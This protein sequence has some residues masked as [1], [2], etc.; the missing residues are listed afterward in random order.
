M[1]PARPAPIDCVDDAYLDLSAGAPVVP[2][3][4]EQL[5]VVARLRQGLR[6]RLQGAHGRVRAPGR[7]AQHRPRPRGDPHR[8]RRA[9]PQLPRVLVRHRA[10]HDVRADVP[11]DRPGD[12]ARRPAR[13]LARRRSTTRTRRRTGSSRRSTPSSAGASRTRRA[14][15]AMWARPREVLDTLR[16]AVRDRPPGG[17]YAVDGTSRGRRR[18]RE[19]AR[20]RGVLRPLR[21]AGVAD[22]RAGPGARG[23]RRRRRRR[24]SRSPTTTWAAAP[25]APTR[26][27]SRPTR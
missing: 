24:C 20:D 5:A 7:H 27:W 2:E 15:C 26:R 17:E 11:R 1:A 9:D 21:R 12:G 13:L 4:A 10:R 25:T 22:A 19:R 14:A 3:T 8:A 18:H 16:A 23:G 6:P